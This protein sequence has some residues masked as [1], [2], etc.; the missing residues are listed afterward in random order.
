MMG[1]SDLGQSDL[2]QSDLGQ[3]DLGQ[4]DPTWAISGSLHAKRCAAHR[5]LRLLTVRP[6][7]GTARSRYRP[8]FFYL[9]WAGIRRYRCTYGTNANRC[10]PSANCC[11]PKVRLLTDRLYPWL[12]SKSNRAAGSCW[13][14]RTEC[15]FAHA[16]SRVAPNARS[17]RSRG[18]E[19]DDR[20]TTVTRNYTV[21]GTGERR[22]FH[23]DQCT[24]PLRCARSCGSGA[25]VVVEWHFYVNQIS[26]SS[27]VP[28]DGRG[29]RKALDR[30]DR[31]DP[32]GCRTRRA[33]ALLVCRIKRHSKERAPPESR[34]Q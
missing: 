11:G 28:Q 17:H 5:E 29:R 20:R 15:C 27:H 19:C 2:G 22:M 33:A 1:L 24:G 25:T 13:L 12:L 23:P 21:A 31:Y 18:S 7:S 6:H 34:R 26:A 3:S 32:Y 10:G 30:A 8:R 14:P 9:G 4:S 16:P